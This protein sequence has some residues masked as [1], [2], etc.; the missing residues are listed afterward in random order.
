MNL[1]ICAMKMLQNYQMLK[2]YPCFE[3]DPHGPIVIESG[4]LGFDDNSQL[5][6]SQFISSVLTRRGSSLVY[7]AKL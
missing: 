5:V 6:S 3:N 2:C 1:T 4:G 7:P